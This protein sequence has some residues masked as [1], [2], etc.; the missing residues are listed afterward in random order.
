[1]KISILVIFGLLLSLSFVSAADLSVSPAKITLNDM[2]RDGYAERTVRFR[3]L[4]EE[5]LDIIID[6]SNT[7]MSDWITVYDENGDLFDLG[8][9]TTI[10]ANK[11]IIL[12]FIMQPK[13]DLANGL[14]KGSIYARTDFSSSN[15][16]ETGSTIQ[17]A[18]SLQ[19]EIGI[20]D[21]EIVECRSD[22][23]EISNIEESDSATLPIRVYNDGNVRLSPKIQIDL[24]NYDK[25]R[26]YSSFIY[27]DKEILPSL[28]EEINIPI[29][30]EDL[31][32]GQYFVDVNVLQ[33]NK[34]KEIS[35]DILEPGEISS[36]GEIVKLVSP[37][38][39]I[40]GDPVSFLVEFKNTGKKKY[41]AYFKGGLWLDD[42]LQATVKSDVL[43]VSPSQT[44][45]FEI[46]TKTKNEGLHY[47]KGNVY[48]DKKRSFEQSATLKVFPES[49]RAEVEEANSNNNGVMPNSKN[50]SKTNY[51]WYIII[52][53]IIGFFILIIRKKKKKKRRHF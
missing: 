40:V 37:I 41:S 50:S 8:A 27:D 24:W 9:K 19:F 18:V 17:I 1:M 38:R 53:I 29:P 4:S 33:C 51:L 46:F 3:T 7:S 20:N 23:G 44:V 26:K 16:V 45:T 15:N 30:T 39:S 13:N 31:L 28:N 42:K 35:F 43:S 36:N 32:S 12:K 14:Y 2:L 49:M 48:Y 6:W 22:I 10:S 52:L 11:P 21:Q 25:S 5:P 34:E 47:L